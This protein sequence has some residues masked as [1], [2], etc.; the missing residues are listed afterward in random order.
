[1]TSHEI[2]PETLGKLI[3]REDRS[4]TR[5]PL[6]V[7]GTVGPV[8]VVACIVATFID[9]Q[10][11]WP[12]LMVVFGLWTLFM[13]LNL[14]G[15]LPIGI[16][17]DG[18]GI[19]IG[20]MRARDRRRRTGR[21][22]PRKPFTV[23]GQS[24]AVFSCPWEGVVALYLITDTREL[25]PMWRQLV[26]FKKTYD[27]AV[28]PLGILRVFFMKAALVIVNDPRHAASDPLEFRSNWRSYGKRIAGV[29]SVTWLVPTRQPEA[30]HAALTQIPGAPPVQ[31]HFPPHADFQFRATWPS[32]R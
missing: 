25:K 14:W 22:P 15:S 26:Q 2:Q 8:L 7:Q 19:Q 23:G 12:L 16:R 5:W 28:T 24:R 18:D 30:L 6:A 20:G 10:A 9:D 29:R 13:T 21:W 31:D 11:T 3:Y 4:A 17:I 27:G 32:A 1:M